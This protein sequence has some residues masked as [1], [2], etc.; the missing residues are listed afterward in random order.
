MDRAATQL[1]NASPHC[2]SGTCLFQS[3]TSTNM[4]E[5]NP[6]TLSAPLLSWMSVPRLLAFLA[7]KTELTQN[8]NSNSWSCCFLFNELS[9][10]H[11]GSLKYSENTRV[12]YQSLI[13]FLKV[14]V[15]GCPRLQVLKFPQWR[16]ATSCS[17]LNL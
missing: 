12:L 9:P 1:K 5:N 14:Q 3:H 7:N 10:K 17:F 11:H 15:M 13:R 6:I 2:E 4:K 16:R 8:K